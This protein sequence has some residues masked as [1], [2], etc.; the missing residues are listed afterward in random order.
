MKLL[1]NM[2]IVALV[3]YGQSVLAMD[4]KKLQKDV[5]SAL[6]IDSKMSREEVDNIKKIGEELKLR[7][8]AIKSDGLKNEI[9]N[10]TGPN[11]QY[12]LEQLD[13]QRIEDYIKTYFSRFDTAL[14]NFNDAIVMLKEKK[15]EKAAENMRTLLYNQIKIVLDAKKQE[16]NEI[17]NASIAKS[18]EAKQKQQ[19]LAQRNIEAAKLKKE[20][21]KKRR[22]EELKIKMAKEEEELKIREE[23]E[24]RLREAAEKNKTPEEKA[25]EKQALE[26]KIREKQELINRLSGA[27][28]YMSEQRRRDAQDTL[29]RHKRKFREKYGTDWV[30]NTKN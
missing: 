3:C 25:K 12:Q 10:M 22:E 30:E 2:M 4:L 24:Q 17:K 18:E 7:V 23:E 1:R 9:K 26:E 27:H 20:E 14:K 15:N 21:Q 16:F 13:I 19:E 8:D 5:K 29:E 11:Q 6:G 28:D